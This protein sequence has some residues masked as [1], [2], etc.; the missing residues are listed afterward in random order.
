MQ[1]RSY[2]LVFN[3]ALLRDGDGQPIVSAPISSTPEGYTAAHPAHAEWVPVENRDSAPFDPAEHYRLAPIIEMD[4][5][6]AYRTYPIISKIDF[7]A[8]ELG[9]P[10]ET[11]RAM[12]GGP[13]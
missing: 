1:E 7:H 2:A 3:G 9:I 13:R 10:A 12:V 4:G 5:G 11:F 6:T 8:K